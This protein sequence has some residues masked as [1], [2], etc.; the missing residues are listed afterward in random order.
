MNLLCIVWRGFKILHEFPTFAF[1]CFDLVTCTCIVH[2]V[3]FTMMNNLQTHDYIAENIQML[4]LI[5]P[6]FLCYMYNFSVWYDIWSICSY[7]HACICIALGKQQEEFQKQL[8]TALQDQRAGFDEQLKKKV[9]WDCF[10]ISFVLVNFLLSY[11]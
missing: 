7:I 11:M 4:G 9:L 5:K 8:E 1:Y 10:A 3:V 6:A 2:V